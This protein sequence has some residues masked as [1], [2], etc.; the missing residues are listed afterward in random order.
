MHT[1]LLLRPERLHLRERIPLPTAATTSDIRHTLG[2]LRTSSAASSG[3][4]NMRRATNGDPKVPHDKNDHHTIDSAASSAT[5]S[6][7][8]SIRSGA[9]QSELPSSPAAVCPST[10][11]TDSSAKATVSSG[12]SH[13][14]VDKRRGNEIF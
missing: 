2:D 5:T 12:E 7:V 4:T 14:V 8:R 3:R 9:T 13:E 1:T 10:T 11:T 6:D